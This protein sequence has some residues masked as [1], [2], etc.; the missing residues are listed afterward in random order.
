LGDK[1]L[2][3][4][5]GN[6]I[7]KYSDE[8]T[9]E[10]QF[11]NIRRVTKHLVDIIEDNFHIALTHGNGPQVGDILLKNEISKEILPSMPIDIAVAQSMGMIGYMLQQS[12]YNEVRERGMDKH[13]ITILTQT[14]VDMNDPCFKKPTKPIGPFYTNKQAESL[15][16][17]K[18]WTLTSE[19]GK[20]FRRVVPSPQP[21]DIIEAVCLKEFFRTGHIII[22]SG[23]G[24]IPVIRDKQNRIRGIEAV[25]D[26]DLAA[27]ILARIL[28]VNI[29]LI[30]TDVE[31]VSINFKKSNQINLNHITVEEAK[32]YLKQGHFPPGSMGPK[33]EAAIN[34][35]EHD[36]E[37]VIITSLENSRKAIEGKAGTS[38]TRV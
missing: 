37:K 34:F 32:D 2:I 16:K 13:I 33:I 26:K 20:G 1:I 29:Y 27:A 10:E 38:I 24:G 21:I 8:G 15:S 35:L 28:G 25:V 3:A 12:L 7:L 19:A 9:A 11:S 22:A 36:G 5:G 14:L 4:L 6:A 23:G 17:E 31:K 30:L 18:G